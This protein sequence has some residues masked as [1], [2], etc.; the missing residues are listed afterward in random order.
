MS[1]EQAQQMLYQL[2]M[3]ESYLGEMT[4]RESTLVGM[5]RETSAAIESINGLG[6]KEKSDTLVPLGSGTFVKTQISSKDK[7]IQNVGAGVAI[8]KEKDAAVN[9]WNQD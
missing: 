6:V 7:I 3:I 2:Q 5:M 1:E 8:E 9:T 4:R